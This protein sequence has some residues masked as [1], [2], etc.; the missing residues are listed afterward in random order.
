MSEEVV[1]ELEVSQ[2]REEEE[3][4]W[5]VSQGIVRNIEISQA[6]TS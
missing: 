2:F 1:R 6:M 4:T 5:D 3:A